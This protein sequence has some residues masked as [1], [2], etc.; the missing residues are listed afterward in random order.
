MKS[1][2]HR[3]E[4]VMWSACLPLKVAISK[5][6]S[7]NIIAVWFVARTWLLYFPDRHASILDAFAQI[8]M[9]AGKI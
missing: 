8:D 6:P 5:M 4:A 3:A 7:Q 2:R 9:Q 1:L